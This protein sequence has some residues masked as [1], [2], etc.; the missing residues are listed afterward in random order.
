MPLN[1]GNSLDLLISPSLTHQQ[2]MGQII[3]AAVLHQQMPADQIRQ[4]RTM[5][6]AIVSGHRAGWTETPDP[7]PVSLK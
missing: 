7:T 3:A 5:L 2:D 6:E 1:N 4:T